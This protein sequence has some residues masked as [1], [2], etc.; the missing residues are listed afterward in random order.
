MPH[1][2]FLFHSL[3]LLP[4][5]PGDREQKGLGAE[6][7]SPWGTCE[8][9]KAQLKVLTPSRVGPGSTSPSPSPNR[10]DGGRLASPK[11]NMEYDVC[12]LSGG[13]L[14]S[15]SFLPVCICHQGQPPVVPGHLP[16][17]RE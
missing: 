7:E 15:G 2:L 5:K 17:D 1:I 11:G 16:E 6:D 4:A 9:Q 12:V 14:G 10:G 13:G 3:P 8:G